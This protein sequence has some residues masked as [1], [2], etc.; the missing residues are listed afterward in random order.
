MCPTFA[1]GKQ[2]PERE[3]V[4][5]SGSKPYA[6]TE[7]RPLDILIEGVHVLK[8][9]RIGC[10][11]VGMVKK[12]VRRVL[13]GVAVLSLFVASAVH[14]RTTVRF[15]TSMG[16][17]DVELF[18]ETTP[19]TVTNFLGIVNRGDYDNTFI[20]RSVPGFII[21]GGGFQAPFSTSAEVPAVDPIMNEPG[22]SNIRGTIAMAKLEGDPN[23]ATTQWFFNLADNS[24]KLDNQNGG[25]TA[26][27]RLVGTGMGVV[28]RIADLP[29]F[30]KGGAFKEIPL[31]SETTTLYNLVIIES[32]TVAGEYSDPSL[33]KSLYF[34]VLPQAPNG[35]NGLAL[36]NRSSAPV[37]L[38][39]ELLS[40]GSAATGTLEVQPNT[41]VAQLVTEI[42]GENAAAPSWIRLH[43]P[44]VVL[45]KHP[46]QDC[47]NEVFD[48][49]IDVFGVYVISTQSAPRSYLLHTANVLAEYI[50]NDLDGVPDDPDVLTY[51]TQNN[52]VVPVWTTEMRGT[53][54]EGARGT[55]CEDNISMAASMYYDEDE[56]AIGGIK[57]AGTWDGNLEEVWHV[58]TRGWSGAY[59]EA[60][61]N[62]E[63]IDKTSLMREAMDVARGGKFD[64]VPS[65]YPA[66]A[67]YTYYDTTCGYHCQFSEY[68]YWALMANMGALDPNITTKCNDSSQEWPLCTRSELEKTDEQVYNLLN[69]SGFRLPRNIPQGKYSSTQLA[70]FFQFGKSDLSQLDGGVAVSEQSTKFYFT[71]VFDGPTSFRG[72][73]ATTTL[74]ILNP[75]STPVTLRLTYVSPTGNQILVLQINPNSLI[76]KS[77]S[78]LFG[79]NLSGGYI[80]AEVIQGDGAV[81]FEIIELPDNSTVLGLNAA[82]ENSGSQVFSAQL[83][84][85]ESLFTNLNLVNTTSE[86]R[87]VILTAVD[88]AGIN[89]GDP[90]E[91]RLEAGAQLSQDARVLFVDAVQDFIGSLRIDS[92][93]SGVLGD[94]IFGD[95]SRLDF[96]AALPLQVETFQEAIFSQLAN[97]LGFF[98]GVALFNPGL[99]DA[100][101]TL[102]VV[103]SQGASVGQVT[104]TLGAGQRVSKLVD[105]FVI[106]SAGQ[107]G[108]FVTIVSDQPLV[109]QMLFGVS[110]VDGITLFSAV[111]PTIVK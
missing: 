82:L 104:Q 21:Q 56:W 32:I 103:S 63:D 89:L 30:D 22:V 73:S 13:L 61:G 5:E 42:F 50:D 97:A 34:P 49:F 84:I 65:E 60:F 46:T 90:V 6:W 110:G 4:R 59:P 62:D 96:A 7:N 55:W 58:V 9:T 68:F 17:F 33:T 38:R 51:L 111:P 75:N 2:S 40:D 98:T 77:V 83:A 37:Q 18:D 39:L 80:K 25:F 72:Q 15:K 76:F 24:E 16:T 31:H 35:F 70:S 102:E 106:D 64:T 88:A 10:S 71:R 85:T 92:D 101:F 53:F 41:Q 87:S 44:T 11:D 54:W 78:E 57:Q 29:I 66:G 8:N 107:V 99:A 36:L 3:E 105:Q 1:D 91:I 94:V 52:Y 109:G 28:N 23:S 48:A 19:I 74:S 69:N 79:E 100:E 47:L 108:G 95:S 20:H 81:G 14:A 43:S 67:W 26:F 27:G 12:W 45:D 86:T 93:G